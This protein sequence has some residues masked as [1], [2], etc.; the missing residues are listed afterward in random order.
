MGAVQPQL[1]EQPMQ[2]QAPQVILGVSSLERVFAMIRDSSR[3]G[4]AV[5]GR[6]FLVLTS[7]LGLSLV[8]LL[9]LCREGPCEVV[10]G[11]PGL[12]SHPLAARSSPPEMVLGV[13]LVPHRGNLRLVRNA[14]IGVETLIGALG[15]LGS[16][17]AWWEEEGCCC[18]V[19]P[20]WSGRRVGWLCCLVVSSSQ[21]CCS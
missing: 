17:R 21:K 5:L 2:T 19:Y 13:L 12:S 6:A 20:V 11:G 14:D 18:S 8:L 4:T 16:N 10:V 1:D 15:S 7:L 3:A 9:R